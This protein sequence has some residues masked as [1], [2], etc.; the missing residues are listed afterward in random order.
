MK[1]TG[2]MSYRSVPGA[3]HRGKHLTAT[4]YPFRSLEPSLPSR[5]AT[6]DSTELTVRILKPS[7]PI[8]TAENYSE[9]VLSEEP[10]KSQ[11]HTYGSSKIGGVRQSKRIRF[12]K[13]QGRLKR[14][15][16][17]PTMSIKDLKLK[18]STHKAIQWSAE[19]NQAND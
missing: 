9:G 4:R 7:D 5:R 17:N 12:N 13:V 1:D 16:I 3:E 14:I 18:V 10:R 8:P 11:V 15:T 19:T 6:F 2:C